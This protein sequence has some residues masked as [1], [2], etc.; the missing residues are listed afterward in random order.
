MPPWL[1]MI[2]IFNVQFYDKVFCTLSLVLRKWRQRAVDMENFQYCQVK[3][4][5]RKKRMFEL[6]YSLV[7]G[8]RCLPGSSFKQR[9]ACLAF[10]KKIILFNESMSSWYGWGM[11]GL[12]LEFCIFSSWLQRLIMALKS[13]QLNV[14]NVKRWYNWKRWMVPVNLGPY[15]LE[16][17]WTHHQLL[18]C[19]WLSHN[20]AWKV[21]FVVTHRLLQLLQL[22]RWRFT[23]QSFES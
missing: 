6:K 18:R 19:I 14:G 8:Q 12:V 7:N 20:P 22:N 15:Q 2:W 10:L 1:C 9:R 23:I 13:G 21:W 11:S 4:C 16:M 5:I 3:F 17:S